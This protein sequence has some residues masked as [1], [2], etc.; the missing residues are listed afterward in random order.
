[1]ATFP[2]ARRG[3]RLFSVE[4]RR[5]G[6]GYDRAIATA[7]GPDAGVVVHS[8]NIDGSIR[9]DGVAPLALAR[10]MI[11]WAYHA[12]DFT[13]RYQDVH[14]QYESVDIQIRIGAWDLFPIRGVLLTGGLRTQPELNQ[15]SRGDM[16]NTLIVELTNHSAQRD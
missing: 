4:F 7:T 2:S 1:V 5:G 16:R 3:G 14:P 12:G 8:F 11:D 15:M 13:I 6:D 9:Y 10:E